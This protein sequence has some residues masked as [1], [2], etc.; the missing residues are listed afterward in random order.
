M[1]S[2]SRQP[3]G[4]LATHQ[5]AGGGGGGRGSFWVP[6]I[7]PKLHIWSE[8]REWQSIVL[9]NISTNEVICDVT[10]QVKVN[11]FD[12]I[13]RC[14][15]SVSVRSLAGVTASQ[16][17][18]FVFQPLFSS[19]RSLHTADVIWGHE[20]KWGHTSKSP[21][22]RCNSCFWFFYRVELEKQP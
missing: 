10:C 21:I 6:S 19:F 20:V 5:A 4:L 3:L 14:V 13:C 7:A 11:F 8:K 22:W 2:L 17:V 18:K 16:V 9:E 15:C 1:R 12:L